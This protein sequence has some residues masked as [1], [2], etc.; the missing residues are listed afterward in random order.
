MD[1]AGQWRQ[2]CLRFHDLRRGARRSGLGARFDALDRDP[3]SR[4]TDWLELAEQIRAKEV[5]TLGVAMPMIDLAAALSR[6]G[7]GHGD[8]RPRDYVCPDRRCVRREEPL[9]GE[10]PRCD[11]RNDKMIKDDDPP[12]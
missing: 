5:Q 11:L 8:D 3:D 1:E 9:L 7:I 6:Q 12:A 4:L 10:A 2:I